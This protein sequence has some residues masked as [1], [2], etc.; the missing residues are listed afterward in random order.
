MRY[1]LERFKEAQKGDLATALAELRAGRKQSHWI[2]YVFPQLRGLGSS[3]HAVHYGV[4]GVGEAR[5]YLQDS[6]LRTRYREA[7]AI[8]HAQVVDNH[9]RLERLMGAHIDALKLVSSLTLFE[10]VAS[11]PHDT[12]KSGAGDE[13]SGIATLAR[14]VLAVAEAQGF[15]QCQFTLG[16]TAK[17]VHEGATGAAAG[18]GR[19]SM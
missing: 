13:L 1:D 5:A 11:P 14:E 7:L 10:H 3:P 18:P 2:W 12:E 16:E 6:L 8:V 4:D 9:L 17:C 15:R 19:D